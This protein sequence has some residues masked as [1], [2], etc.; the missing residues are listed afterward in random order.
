[1]VIHDLRNPS[2]QIKYAVG[3]VMNKLTLLKQEEKIFKDTHSKLLDE[4]WEEIQKLRT[5][6]QEQSQEIYR[7][8]K[9]LDSK[10]LVIDT[11]RSYH[12]ENFDVALIKERASSCLQENLVKL[13]SVNQFHFEQHESRDEL[14]KQNLSNM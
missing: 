7:L 6:C 12:Q 9:M 2:N 4:L 3:H 10:G 13:N 8:R 5:K 14:M 1:M 11:K